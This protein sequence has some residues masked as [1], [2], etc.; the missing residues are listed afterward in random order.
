L[1]KAAS[2]EPELAKAVLPKFAEVGA[3]APIP[4]GNIPKVIP[5]I[6]NTPKLN[7]TI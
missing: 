4:G 3:P 5:L 2:P 1:A 7:V 6:V